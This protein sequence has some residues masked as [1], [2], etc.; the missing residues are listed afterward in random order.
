[1]LQHFCW[2]LERNLELK[3]NSQ[4]FRFLFL[5]PHLFHFTSL[6]I[7]FPARPK[8]KELSFDEAYERVAKFPGLDFE[9]NFVSYKVGP[10]RYK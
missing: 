4:S 9:H 6:H 3:K 1:M 5:Q 8:I 10:T 2:D 7:F